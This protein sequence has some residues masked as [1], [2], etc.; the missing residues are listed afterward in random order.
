MR[1]LTASMAALCLG[2]WVAAP[3]RAQEP[4]FTLV[5]PVEINGLH[6][7]ITQ[8]RVD[9]FVSRQDPPSAATY[10]MI[11]R[12]EETIDLREGA[13]AGDVTVT[14][15]PTGAWGP[16]E[17]RTYQCTLY[18]RLPRGDGTF[19]DAR[20]MSAEGGVYFFEEA[21]LAPDSPSRLSVIGS[22]TA[23]E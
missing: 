20:Q 17:G 8:G 5:V 7:S 22:L 3:A 6:S 12:G 1:L 11:A 2:L 23:L 14:L 13:Y 10:A 15:N 4:D 21:R 19:W 16:W 18:L 9:C